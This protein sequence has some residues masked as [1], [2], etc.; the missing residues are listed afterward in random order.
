MGLKAKIQE[1]LPSTLEEVLRRIDT[2]L[3]SVPD[4]RS[5]KPKYRSASS[6]PRS[7]SASSAAV[8]VDAVTSDAESSAG[9]QSAAAVNVV[10]SMHSYAMTDY[11]HKRTKITAKN[12]TTCT[13][14]DNSAINNKSETVATPKHRVSLKV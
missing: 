8:D 2:L 6:V 7:A 5:L 10:A 14:D 3:Q 11:V 12:Y 1:D 9:I 4:S 13:S